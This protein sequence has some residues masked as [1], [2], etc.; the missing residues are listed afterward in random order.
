MHKKRQNERP[1]KNR[2]VIEPLNQKLCPLWKKFD[3]HALQ[4]ITSK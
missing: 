3:V 4:K 1:K 2:R